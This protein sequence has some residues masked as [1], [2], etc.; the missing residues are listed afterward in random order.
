M[1]KILI[2]I[3]LSVVLILSIIKLELSGVIY[4]NDILSKIYSVHGLDISHHQSKINW[5]KI[6]TNKY[7][8]ILMKATEGKN[9]LD[10]DYF[11]NFD[12]AQSLGLNVGVYHFFTMTST[13]REQALFYI[14][15]VPKLD[16]LIPPI[17]DLEVSIKYDKEEV[18]K[19]LKTMIDIL[20]NHY[21]KRVIIYV[22]SATYTKYIKGELLDNPLWIRNIKWYPNIEEKDRWVFW[23]Y[24]NRG[25]IKAVNGFVDKNVFRYSDILEFIEKSKIK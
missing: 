18:L 6:D 1:R 24:S 12:K 17:I 10:R 14:S 5:E 19:E 22:T 25:R 7:D 13:G 8:F 16:N 23:Q 21:K 9:F 3:T 15:K 11:Y 4:H 20:E 2:T